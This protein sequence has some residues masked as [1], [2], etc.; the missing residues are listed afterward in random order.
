MDQCRCLSVCRWV[1]VCGGCQL[2]A[3]AATV[4]CVFALVQV[5][6]SCFSLSPVPLETKDSLEVTLRSESSEVL[7]AVT[8]EEE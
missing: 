3:E 5:H 4:V 8:E 2:V 7:L 1:F 6:T